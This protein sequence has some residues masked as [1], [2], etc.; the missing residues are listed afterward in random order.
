MSRRNKH[1][2]SQRPAAPPQGTRARLLAAHRSFADLCV[3]NVYKLVPNAPVSALDQ[4]PRGFV[5]AVENAPEP[6]DLIPLRLGPHEGLL[7]LEP[8]GVEAYKE[9][10]AHA[11]LQSIRFTAREGGAG[12]VAILYPIE[13][14]E[15]VAP[16]R[17]GSPLGLNAA[18]YHACLMLTIITPAA[19][20][21]W[22]AN[23]IWLP[24]MQHAH[25]TVSSTSDDFWYSH[26]S[27]TSFAEALARA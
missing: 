26:E 16:L 2:K 24:E 11:V 23:T 6:I 12:A 21:S 20:E 4:M 13:I 18:F 7:D 27:L 22:L 17:E 3:D 14:G 10:D 5:V 8:A 19:H 15:N 1:R 25:T 9:A